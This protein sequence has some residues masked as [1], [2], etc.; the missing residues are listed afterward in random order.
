VIRN[1]RRE[2]IAGP[3]RKDVTRV[4]QREVYHKVRGGPSTFEKGVFAGR[5]R[6]FV[7]LNPS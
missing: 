6:K 1:E 4:F 7:D 2:W 5:P 3:L